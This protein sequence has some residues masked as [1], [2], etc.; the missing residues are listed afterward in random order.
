MMLVSKNIRHDEV[1]VRF[2]IILV[3]RSWHFQN[4]LVTATSGIK[5]LCTHVVF[6]NIFL[7]T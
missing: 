1:V 2:S 7:H 4:H 6:H 5:H 3:E